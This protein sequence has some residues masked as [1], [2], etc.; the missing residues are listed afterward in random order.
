MAYVITPMDEEAARDIAGWRYDPP[1]SFY[2]TVPGAVAALLD[3]ANAYYA[4]RTADGKL[5][6][7]FCFGAEA[8]VAGGHRQGLYTGPDTLDIGLGMRPDLTGHGQGP[9]FVQ[10]GLDFARRTFAPARFRLSVATFNTRAIRVYRRAG[11]QPGPVFHSPT[12]AGD[13]EFLLM[14]REAGPDSPAVRREDGS[15]APS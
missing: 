7:F 10:A 8:Q 15:A 5:A 1:Y 14:T 3:P 11:F 6:G 9:A 13:T 4:V 12:A 2:N